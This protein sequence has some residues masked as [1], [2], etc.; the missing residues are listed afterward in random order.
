[1]ISIKELEV[2]YPNNNG[3]SP[4][5]A[6]TNLSLNVKNG[7]F[8]SIV[9]PSGC[10]KTTLLKCLGGLISID[11]GIVK[12]DS[13]SPETARKKRLFAINFQDSALIPN[14]TA[15]QNAQLPGEIFGKPEMDHTAIEMMKIVGLEGYEHLYPS[16][17]SGGMKARVALARSLSLTP[18][19]LLMDEPFGAVDALT[20]EKLNLDLEM[21]WR[22]RPSTVI[23]V[24]HSIQEACFLGDRVAVMT[25]RPGR[26]HKVID[27]PLKRPR[28]LSDQ[29]GNDFLDCMKRVRDALTEVME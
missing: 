6:L 29:F 19:V 15:I 16:Q 23:L 24:T 3:N 10:G 5:H 26:I 4:L 12:V 20:R 14:R 2:I 22:N 28:K 25:S 13:V 8:L 7:E 11:K 18:K 17:L 9:G 21:I 1:M 27:V